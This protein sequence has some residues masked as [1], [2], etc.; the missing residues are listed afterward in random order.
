MQD[1]SL[2]SRSTHHSSQNSIA[3]LHRSKTKTRDQ[4]I[5]DPYL[6]AASK[7]KPGTD[8]KATDPYYKMAQNLPIAHISSQADS[9]EQNIFGGFLHNGY[10]VL[11]RGI[12]YQNKTLLSDTTIC[13]KEKGPEILFFKPGL[14]GH[15]GLEA[16]LAHFNQ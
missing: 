7:T 8:F 15:A 9:P 2:S 6:T 13:E 10:Q 4:K 16:T 1:L 5:A 11:D 3:Q 12:Y 14:I